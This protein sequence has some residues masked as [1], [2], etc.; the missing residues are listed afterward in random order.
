MPLPQIRQYG[1]SRQ[2]G[3]LYTSI[4]NLP[5]SLANPGPIADPGPHPLVGHDI[6]G[7]PPSL[8]ESAIA[9]LTFRWSLPHHL[10]HVQDITRAVVLNVG[11]GNNHALRQ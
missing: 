6:P 10:S 7:A 8:S 11:T 4:T 9:A 3:G 1:V 2:H 5:S